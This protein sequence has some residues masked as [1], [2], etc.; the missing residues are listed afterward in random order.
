MQTTTPVSTAAA[1]WNRLFHPA[2]A[3]LSVEAAQS[4]LQIE[5][6]KEDKERMHELAAK[7]RD[8]SLSA[9]EQEE[10]RTYE[11]VGNLLG[12]LKSKARQRLKSVPSTN[13]LGC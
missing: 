12:V 5:F 4:L 11:Q 8:G 13:G 10:I 7:A 9:T 6:P 2:G 1:I 3:A